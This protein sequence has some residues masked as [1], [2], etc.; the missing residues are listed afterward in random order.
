MPS[1]PLGKPAVLMDENP[2]LASGVASH[3]PDKFAR[4]YWDFLAVVLL[5]LVSLPVTWLSPK[6]V[7]VIP[8]PGVF[9]DHW[10]IDT[11]FRAAHGNWFGRDVAFV[12]GPLFEWLFSAPSRWAG[13][14]LTAV[15]ATYNTLLLWFTFF[16]G[17]FTLRLLLPEQPNW[18]RFLLLL[19]LCVFWAPWDGRTACALFL[20]ALFL[21]GWYAVR[22]GHLKPI[23]LGGGA[24]VLC[25]LAFLYSADT[26]VYGIAAYLISLAGVAMES[27]RAAKLWRQYFVALVSFAGV[28]VALILPINA[29][30]ASMLD[31]RFWRSSLALV[32]IHRWNEASPM[33]GDEAK[34]L[35]G[36]LVAGVIILLVRRFVR[37]NSA[38]TITARPGFLLSAFAFAVLAMQSGLVRSDPMHVVFAVFCMVFFSAVV[39]FSFRSRSVSVAAAVAVIGCS[40][41]FGLPT[42]MFRP[43]S[44]R[45]RLTQ[46][47]HATTECPAGF[48]NFSDVCYPAQFVARLDIADSY[49][50]HNSKSNDSILIFP[51]QYMYGMTSGHNVA[52]GV[53]QSFLA[54]GPYLSQLDIAGLSKAAAPVGLYFPDG[55]LSLR[56]DDVSNFTRT[57]EIWLWILSRY[58]AGP[59]LFPGV[60]AL[61]RADDRALRVSMQSVSIGLAQRTYPIAQRNAVVN[62]GAPSWPAGT[63]FLKLRLKVHYGI[64]WNLRKPERLQLEITRADGS[65]DMRAFVIQPNAVSEVWF[66]PWDESGLANYFDHDQ[67]RWRTT[68]RSAITQLRLITTPFDWVSQQPEAISIESAEAVKI[69]MIR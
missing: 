4:R 53:V 2:S 28:F 37:G 55:E 65:H 63:D 67:D 64:L 66:Y 54:G 51:Y 10:D 15:Y 20:F 30:M 8:R 40:F 68:P 58:E 60:V 27:G 56:I 24:A 22:Q 32:S 35:I 18:K 61:Q 48:E 7:M 19:L 36:S 43:S 14:S 49:L 41:A 23:V 17:Y 13:L 21:R 47:R 38:E 5:V 57:P 6:T 33:G 52:G 12:Y 31:F 1:A 45:Y 16:L 62:L 11:V 42:T 46:L 59:Q 44:L 29:L 69:N 25:A 3:Q 34:R 50:D 39:L 9:D 26:G